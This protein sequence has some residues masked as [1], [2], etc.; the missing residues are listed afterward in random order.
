MGQ[1]RKHPD[2]R[3]LEGGRSHSTPINKNVPRPQS[4]RPPCPGWLLTEAKRAWG[5]LCRQLEQMGI[6]GSADQAVMVAYCL[7]WETAVLAQKR[8]QQVAREMAETARRKADAAGVEPAAG[9]M[10][11]GDWSDAFLMKTTNGNVVQSALM[12]VRNA[13]LER[14][15]NCASKLGLSPTDRA[16]LTL[17]Q[18]N[19]KSLRERL[20]G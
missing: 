17:E 13:A 18:P 11:S 7:E 3:A 16:K 12:G 15:T 8:M 2:L 20:M 4:S 14:M 10:D 19:K 5:Y 6:I 9:R 1:R